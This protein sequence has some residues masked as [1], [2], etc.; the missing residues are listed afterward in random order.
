M[1]TACIADS[2]CTTYF[3]E[4]HEAF[5]TYTPLAKAASQS[6]KEGINFTILGMGTVQMKVVHNGLEQTLTFGNALYAPDVTADLISTSRFNLT[7][8]DVVFGRKRAHFFRDKKE[9]FGGTLKNGP[10]WWFFHIKYPSCSYCSIS[11]KSRDIALWHRR[12]S[13]FG[14]NRIIEASK[15]VDGLEITSKDVIGKCEDCIIGNQKRRPYNEE[16][17]PETEVL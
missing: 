15:L 12:F 8:W 2:G 5:S 13:H 9:I 16:I 3:F 11:S 4:S 10:H 6:S 14:I 1:G 7:G 17:T